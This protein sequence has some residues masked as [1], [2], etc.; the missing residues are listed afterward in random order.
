[1]DLQVSLIKLAKSFGH[2]IITCDYLPNNP[3]HKFSDEY[4]NV[5]TTNKEAVYELAKKLEIDGILAYASDPAAP[6][7]AWVCEKL[8]L[9]TNTFNAVNILSRKDLFRQTLIDNGFKT[10]QFLTTNNY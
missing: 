8:N 9:P 2:Y 6:T 10:P 4:H 7:A 1:S 5:S 3:G